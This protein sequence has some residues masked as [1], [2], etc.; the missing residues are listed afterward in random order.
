MQQQELFNQV[1]L[2]FSTILSG[3]RVRKG[4]LL[5][6]ENTLSYRL[7]FV[8]KGALRSFYLVDGRDV[9]A[10]FAFENGIVGAA[11]SIIRG[12]KS[13]YA[14]EA[15]ED[16][17]LYVMD[18]RKM[19]QLLASNPALERWA[20]LVSQHL[21]IELVERLEGMIF[22]PASERY[23]QLISRYPNLD[24]K[25]NLGHIASYLGISQETLS[26]VRSGK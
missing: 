26:R 22:L 13:R 10:H 3:N 25:V 24:Q 19:E 14:I 12:K 7:Y 15:L 4:E 8:K 9:T 18:Y 11:D 1:I 6:Q 23:H 16:S 20:R 2:H 5:Q 21:Y 17:E